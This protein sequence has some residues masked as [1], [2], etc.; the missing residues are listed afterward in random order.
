MFSGTNTNTG[1]QTTTGEDL[2]EKLKSVLE[3][4][5]ISLEKIV[6]ISTNGASAVKYESGKAFPRY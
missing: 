5:S 4:F 1:L 3:E 2:Q 6:S